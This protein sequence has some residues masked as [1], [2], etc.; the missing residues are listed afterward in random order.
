MSCSGRDRI[1]AVLDRVDAAV[2][3]LLGL[4]FDTLTTPER[5][6]VLERIERVA[7]RLPVPGHDLINQI[8]CQASP[9]E[10]GG[11]LAHALAARLHITRGDARRRIDE[12]ADLGA[13]RAV[14][15]E[16]LPA[17]LAATAA[18]QRDGRIG[19]EH[20]AVIR[21]FDRQLPGFVDPATREQAEADLADGAARFRPEQLA[22]LAE[23]LADCL[24]P[25]GNFTD[26]DRAN[27]RG[28]TLG[29]QGA[30]GMSSLAG[31]LTPEL[32]ATL[33]A[34]WAKLAAPG[35]AN[36]EDENPTVDGTPAQGTI[37]ADHRS[38]AQRQHDAL[39]AGLRALLAS[40]ELGQHNGL[41]TSIIVTTTLADLEAAAGHGL[42]GGGTLLPISDV[43]RLARH[44]HHY[45]A[46]FEQGRAL[47]LYHTKRLASPGQRI[48]LYA[49]DR[50]CSHPD[51]S[52]PGYYCEVHHATDYAQCRRTD[53]DDLTLR[54]GPHH[55]LITSGDWVT[56]RRR[57][58]TIET[59]PPPH[60]DHG[61]PRINRYH[62]VCHERVL[63][64]SM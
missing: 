21:R 12:A 11:K 19:R 14:T 48:V 8:A 26:T 54:C 45:L 2:D 50:G 3:E 13:R 63:E 25:D 18:R 10:L 33:E 16:E 37:D 44:A 43:I 47:G 41:P 34:V 40:G 64:V 27:R 4:R 62:H 35:M 32:R 6:R 53:I 20:I 38:P 42:T 46:V 1:G 49:R 29:R 22:R 15:G 24:N 59:I 17:R 61:Q 7:R 30:D 28:I 58:G 55:G 5:L 52:V 51:C 31:W 39:T 23:H 9:D 57:D 36:P 56:R 60:L